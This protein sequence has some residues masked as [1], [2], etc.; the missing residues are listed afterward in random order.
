[1]LQPYCLQELVGRKG[2]ES[3]EYPAEMKK[4]DKAILRYF[5]QGNVRGKP[6]CYKFLCPFNREQVIFFQPAVYFFIGFVFNNRIQCLLHYIKNKVVKLQFTCTLCLNELKDIEVQEFHF[7]ACAH[8]CGMQIIVCKKAGMPIVMFQLFIKAVLK[9]K[10][11]AF[12]G[13][14]MR[15]CYGSFIAR[16]SDEYAAA[17]R[18]QGMPENIEQEISFPDKADCKRFA[19]FRFRRIAVRT[20]APEIKYPVKI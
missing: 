6:A 7:R 16:L 3:L 1:M 9:I 12:I 4:A 19:V 17:V 8:K 18:I 5:G 13:H 20:P 10:N 14:C 2:S 15:M 11:R